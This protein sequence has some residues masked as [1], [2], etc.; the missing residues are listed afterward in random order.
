M[1]GLSSRRGMGAVGFGNALIG[2]SPLVGA[3]PLSLPKRTSPSGRLN[4][5]FVHKRSASV[6]T[7]KSGRRDAERH[8]T[9]D[10]RPDPGAML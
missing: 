4:V 7:Q 6:H 2:T 3:R 8:R 5:C 9:L 1:I 10:G